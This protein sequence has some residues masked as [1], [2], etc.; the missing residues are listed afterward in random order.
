LCSLKLFRIPKG[1]DKE[2]K[3]DEIVAEVHNLHHKDLRS[4]SQAPASNYK[5][6]VDNAEDRRHRHDQAMK[7]YDETLK[8]IAD[9]LEEKVVAVGTAVR[10][11]L[12]ELDFEIS[13]VFD[14][15]QNDD[16]LEQQPSHSYVVETWKEIN[17]LCAKQTTAIQVLSGSWF[18]P[19]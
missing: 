15:L 16:L 13:K 2:R 8:Y 5:K 19:T 9:Q 4:E 7:N 6:I 1:E 10:E 11:L 18:R 17:T 12:G 3:A 14:D